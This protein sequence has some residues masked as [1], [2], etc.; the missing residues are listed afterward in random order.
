M[1]SMEFE[2]LILAIALATALAMRPWRMLRTTALLTPLL[3][4]LALG[5]ALWAMPRLPGMP[6]PLQWSGACLVVLMVGWPLA[7]PLLC[8]VA[9]LSVLW[10]DAS[11]QALAQQALWQ[12]VVPATLAVLWGAVLRRFA[13]DNVFVYT[14]ARACLGTVLSLFAA[15][16]LAQGMGQGIADTGDGSSMVIAA[17]LIA[18]GDGFL[19]GLLAAIGV[20]Y[21]PQY[22]ATWSDQRYL[23]P[24]SASARRASRTKVDD[25][26]D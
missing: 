5:P 19:T 11:A 6:L 8:A 18:W 9:A 12:G 10:A 14:L 16:L 2:P 4:V 21:A 24:P 20:A 17:W 22:L 3:A 1:G 26:P 13:P 23:R 15:Q 7:V 25:N